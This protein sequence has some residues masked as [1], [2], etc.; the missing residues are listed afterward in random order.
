MTTQLRVNSQMVGRLLKPFEVQLILGLGRSKVYELIASG[1]FP[2]VRLG[3]R[4]TRVP[5]DGLRRW[6]AQQTAELD[7]AA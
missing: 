3:S 2:V 4:T 5:E 7:A 6:I 1:A